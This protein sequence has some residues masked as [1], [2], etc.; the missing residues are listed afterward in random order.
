LIRKISYIKKQRYC[1]IND[2]VAALDLA[3][4]AG[5]VF[6]GGHYS[7]NDDLPWLAD[8]IKLIR[9]GLKM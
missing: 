2:E 8:E 1:G 7:V 3:A 4:V 6:M 9:S 5:L